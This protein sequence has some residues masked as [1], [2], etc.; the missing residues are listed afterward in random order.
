MYTKRRQQV[1]II[2]MN[3]RVHITLD[4]RACVLFERGTSRRTVIYQY[5]ELVYFKNHEEHTTNTQQGLR[6][7]GVPKLECA[8]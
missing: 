2:G 5:T 8:V 3:L 1:N 4:R 7:T 6:F